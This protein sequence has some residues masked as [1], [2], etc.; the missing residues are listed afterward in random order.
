MAGPDS[1]KD[2]ETIRRA[3]EIQDGI[4]QNSKIL[5]FQ[6]REETYPHLVKKG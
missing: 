6:N 5:S 3:I 1:W 2:N 4:I